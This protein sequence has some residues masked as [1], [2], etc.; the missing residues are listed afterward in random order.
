MANERTTSVSISV[1]KGGIA[2]NSG[3]L[4]KTGDMTGTYSATESQL[5]GTSNEA[6]SF[7]TTDITGDVNVAV[8]N[9]D[10]A[11]YVEIFKDSGNTHLL[12]KLKAGESCLLMNIP[13]NALYGRANT[14]AVSIQF[15]IAQA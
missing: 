3:T 6:L 7:N 1:S 2:I 15:W 8:K 4:S 13:H 5:I 9:M 11:N 10:A 14:A 12:S